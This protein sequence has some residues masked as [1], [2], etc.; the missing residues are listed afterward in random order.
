[1]TVSASNNGVMCQRCHK[2]VRLERTERVAEEFSIA[3]PHCGFRGIYR[4]KDIK[5][6]GEN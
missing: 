3:C 4:I 1:M 6:L 2:P 5:P